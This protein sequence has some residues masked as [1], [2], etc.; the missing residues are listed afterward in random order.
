MAD[1][2]N[3]L[4][5]LRQTFTDEKRPNYQVLVP[6]MKGLD[7][8]IA[9]EEQVKNAGLGRL[10]NEIALFVPAS[11][12]SDST[13]RQEATR[14][15]QNTRTDHQGFCKANNG[16]TVDKL[17]ASIPAVVEKASRH[18]YRVRGYVSVVVAC[19]YDGKV[20]PEQ[21]RRV[22]E[23]LDR[24]GCYEISLGDTTGQG[25]PETWKQLWKY[26]EQSGL[27]MGKVAVSL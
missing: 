14:Q 13:S 27:D 11:D 8:L 6:N 4:Q 10:T 21:V 25:S 17:L 15:M 16:T 26:L 18:G 12:V 20:S 1:T 19:P 9:L 22:T 5:A 7:N 23:V 3:L 24:I 2:P